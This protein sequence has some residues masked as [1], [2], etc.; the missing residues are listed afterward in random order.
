MDCQSNNTDSVIDFVFRWSDAS[1]FGL[2]SAFIGGNSLR[3]IKFVSG[4]LT[5]AGS[6][7]VT[8]AINTAYTLTA[9][10]KGNAISAAING[11]TVSLSDSH[12]ATATRV[13]IGCTNS[14]TNGITQFDNLEVLSNP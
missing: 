7:S 10:A 5:V 11:Q 8:L 4:T 2:A 9:E 14:A 12:N 6:V 1:N 3:L 13:G